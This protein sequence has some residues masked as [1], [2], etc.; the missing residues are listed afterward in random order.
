GVGSCLLRAVGDPGDGRGVA[1]ELR[2]RR[3]GMQVGASHEI[4][5]EFREY[6]RAWTTAADAY[7]APVVSRYVSALAESARAAGLPEPLVMRSSGGT[8]SVQEAAAHPAILLVSGPAGG[9]VGAGRVARLAG[10][11]DAIALRMGGTSTDVCLLPGGAAERVG[12]R[13]VGGLPIRLPTLD[14]H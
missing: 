3:P 2:R 12:Q 14:V 8:A 13:L 1:A 6:G 9:V 11:A 4:A 5:P 10:F 7:L